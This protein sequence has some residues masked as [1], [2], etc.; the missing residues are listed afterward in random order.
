M[1]ILKT[2][3]CQKYIISAFLGRLVFAGSPELLKVQ[4]EDEVL[5]VYLTN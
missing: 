4:S 1:R 5:M 3:S 2:I